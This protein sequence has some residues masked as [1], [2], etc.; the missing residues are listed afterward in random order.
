MANA[1]PALPPFLTLQ[2]VADILAVSDKTVR[3]LIARG[4]LPRHK[5]GRQVRISERDL[6]DFIALRRGF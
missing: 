2:R 3:R 4:D 1:L 5:V 6:R